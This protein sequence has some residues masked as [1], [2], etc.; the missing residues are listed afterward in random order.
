[1]DEDDPLDRPRSHH[2]G[3]AHRADLLRPAPSERPRARRQGRARRPHVVHQHGPRRHRVTGTCCGIDY[4]R[5][6][7]GEAGWAAYLKQKPWDHLPGGLLLR[8][9]GG[10]VTRRGP[11]LVARSA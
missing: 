6:A 1:M 2:T 4:P 11:L 8:E 3:H 7:T 10:T 9:A 5:L